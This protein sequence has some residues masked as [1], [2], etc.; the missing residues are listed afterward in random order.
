MEV[1]LPGAVFDFDNISFK[2]GAMDA[3]LS[4][5]R[6][7]PTDPLTAL[8]YDPERVFRYHI[9]ARSLSNVT[10]YRR[11]L[12][13]FHGDDLE[14]GRLLHEAIRLAEQAVIDAATSINPA[15]TDDDG[16]LSYI[17]D[18]VFP[19][20]SVN[21]VFGMGEAGKSLNVQAALTK[22]SQGHE[23]ASKSTSPVNTFWLDYE[24]DDPEDFGRR[25]YWLE[26]GGAEFYPGSIR[27]MAARGVPFVDLADKV[28][29]EMIRFNSTAFV[30][31][32][33][34]FACGDDPRKEGTVTQFYGA[35]STLPPSTKILI[36]HTDK[37][38]N[39]KYPLGSIMW[40]N[41]VHGMSW[42]L[43]AVK[44][45]NELHVGWYGRKA[46]NAG[47]QYDFASRFRFGDGACVVE[48]GNLAA[49]NRATGKAS[50]RD[51]IL[52]LLAASEMEVKEISTALKMTPDRVSPYLSRML[53][54]GEI[55]RGEDRRWKLAM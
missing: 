47:V 53:N 52:A 3:V 28:R 23:W 44:S 40:H 9:S 35:L 5:W 46:S 27:W 45:E 13:K 43:K 49:I 16:V 32:S 15:A 20:N 26:R 36:A 42:Y 12:E 7:V 19:L 31:D 2:N 33:I 39:D 51:R 4:V 37:A 8:D 48:S 18:G 11:E 1:R 34:I 55:Q 29:R 14:W 38:E 50:V 24:A 10:A 22:A 30:L 21:C 41:G 17:I 54:A 6:E 25:R